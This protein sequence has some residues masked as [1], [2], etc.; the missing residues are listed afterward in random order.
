MAANS[1]QFDKLGASVLNEDFLR[2]LDKDRTEKGCEYAVLV[3]LLEPGSE[4]YNTGIVDVST[5]SQ[6]STSFDRSFSSP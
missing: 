2:K 3:S 6:R 4:L 5:A 1:S